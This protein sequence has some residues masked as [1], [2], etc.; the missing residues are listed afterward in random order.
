MGLWGFVGFEKVEG[1]AV[2]AMPYV[3]GLGLDGRLRRGQFARPCN[4][5]ASWGAPHGMGPG[6]CGPA[7]MVPLVAMAV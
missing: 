3:L 6:G 7:E 4:D 5:R 1:V 2:M